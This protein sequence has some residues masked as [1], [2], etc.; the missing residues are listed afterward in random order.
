ML[1]YVDSAVP[2][3]CATTPHAPR[4]LRVNHTRPT[5][6]LTLARFASHLRV[7]RN[8]H[9]SSAERGVKKQAIC[10]VCNVVLTPKMTRTTLTQSLNYGREACSSSG[11]CASYGQSWRHS[12]RCVVLVSVQK[13]PCA[14]M[15]RAERLSRYISNLCG[16]DT[17]GATITYFENPQ[18]LLVSPTPARVLTF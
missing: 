11:S 10:T 6:G 8:R 2:L 17:D 18:R 9:P 15:T 14:F 1:S 7:K 4:R 5:S 12:A 16:P 3:F 13:P